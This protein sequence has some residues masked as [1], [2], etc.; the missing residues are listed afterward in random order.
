MAEQVFRTGDGIEA[1]G[2]VTGAG[3]S[4]VDLSAVDQHILPDVDITRDLGSPTKQWR[5]VYVGPGSLYVNGQKVI[6]DNSGT[7]NFTA[8]SNQ[9]LNITT[10]G[11]GDIEF[12]TGT[13][14][15]ECKA[16]LQLEAGNSITSSDAN[17]VSINGGI[18]LN[19]DKIINLGTP[20]LATDAASKGYV[21]T[22]IT[23]GSTNAD[24][25]NVT[26]GGLLNSDDI[27][28]ATMTASGNVIVQG[29]LTVNGTTTTIN[30]STLSIA[31]TSVILNSDFT[32]GS[33]TA[34]QDIV[35]TR[36]NE[37]NTSIR[38][39]ETSDVWELTN[40]GSSFYE[41]ITTN[42]SSNQE[43]IED[44]VGAMVTANTEAGIA[45]TYD[46]GTGKLNFNVNDPTITLSGDVTGSAV[47]SNLGNVTISATVVNDSHTHDTIYPRLNTTENITANWTMRTI[48]P[49]SNN[50]YNLGSGALKYATV[51]ATTF[52]GTA[53]TAQYADLAEKY[54]ADADYAPGTV[55]MF[56]GD[57][58]VTEASAGTTAVAG[59][60]STDPAYLMNS[61]LE[62]GVA[63][64]LR[65][66][67]PC[68]VCGDIAKGDLMVAGE[69]G[70][71][72]ADNDANPNA[73]IGRA[74]EAHS[75][76]EGVIEVVVS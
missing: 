17:E 28:A 24:F 1:D 47:M 50:T 64:A 41:I 61:A 12:V 75:G 46:D 31:D 62:G 6:E 44:I 35:A 68:K 14:K 34:N 54:T 27:T 30:S 56:G 66:R 59:I 16:T 72:V 52:D 42:T 36:G 15:I 45:V 51:Y 70:C 22:Q 49:E 29:D 69:G 38:W 37:N 32:T 7:I 4:G 5:D 43:E 2:P 60:V 9:N 10:Q 25:N 20:T 11:S 74:L 71:A 3:G 57:A 73:V 67:V 19:S 58:E 48:T 18:D 33:P 55:V 40:D 8:D 65:G 23:G 63:V 26:V 39:N 76:D 21:D 13:G 53:T